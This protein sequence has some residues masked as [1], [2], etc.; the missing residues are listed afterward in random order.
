MRVIVL[1]VGSRGD[2][3]PF[4]A[5]IQRLLL[6]TLTRDNNNKIIIEID[7]FVEP[8]HLSLVTP[9]LNV[10][11]D[12]DDDDDD[13]DNNHRRLRIHSFP[14]EQV[15]FVVKQE[16]KVDAI[17]CNSSTNCTTERTAMLL[18]QTVQMYQDKILPCLDMIHDTIIQK[19]GVDYIISCNL[20][21]VLCIL[22]KQRLHHHHQQQQQQQQL[23]GRM[24]KFL[25]IQLQPLAPNLIFPC[26]RTTSK[27]VV[28]ESILDYFFWDD[29]K[30]RTT[31]NNLAGRDRLKLNA[32]AIDKWNSY[33]EIDYELHQRLFTGG[34]PYSSCTCTWDEWKQIFTGNDPNVMIIN[35][36]SKYLIPEIT[37]NDNNNKND[38]SGSGSNEFLLGKNIMNVGPL[39]DNY[40][41]GN[42][43]DFIIRRNVHNF[44]Q[45]NSNDDDNT[46]II[47]IGF[48]SMPF[49]RKNIM[50][51]AIKLLGYPKTI[52]IGD[53]LKP[54]PND[55]TILPDTILHVPSI[56]Y[57][58]LFQNYKNCS[59]MVCHGGMGV[60]SVCLRYGIPSIVCPMMGD[61]YLTGSL[62]QG[63]GLGRQAGMSL[64]TI[65][66]QDLIDTIEAVR[67]SNT[68]RQ[69]CQRVSELI[70]NEKISGVD[71]VIR[72]M[73][74]E[75]VETRNLQ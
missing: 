75:Q 64:S 46:P 71:H 53:A 42:D 74:K 32:T 17:C 47:C 48:G 34:Q 15:G 68:I 58:W 12:D 39:A 66:S 59:M 40:Y 24:P 26:Y 4:C 35:A 44:C 49:H 10:S 67:N 52:F 19:D 1:S 51:D 61:Q 18:D 22:L 9:L 14:F 72:W 3:E 37:N 28:V 5:L 30:D 70:Q 57:P 31:N 65:T 43:H 6:P 11:N 41:L 60:L 29:E 56:P 21:N 62:I 69:R 73:M 27:R 54:D 55:G 23:C 63:L 7:F 8:N 16:G 25:F 50:F 33:W 45:T 2:V 13:D 38:D 20:T 36:Y